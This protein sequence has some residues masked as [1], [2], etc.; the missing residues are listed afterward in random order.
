M[1]IRDRVAR[2]VAAAGTLLV[3]ALAGDELA[4]TARESET[5]ALLL[6]STTGTLVLAGAQDLIVL[7]T[8]FLLASIP[9]YALIGLARDP[10][11]AEAAMKA[12]LMGALFGIVL[13]LG[14][15]ILYALSLI[16]I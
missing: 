3:L 11:G 7:M 10:R 2:I 4:G 9:L 1:C 15:T 8:G 13:M 12:Y 6:F 16:H 5:Y 14:V